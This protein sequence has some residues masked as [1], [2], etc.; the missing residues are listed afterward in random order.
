MVN[1]VEIKEVGPR[2]GAQFEG[3][4]DPLHWKTHE[5]V[6]LVYALARAGIKTI[7]VTS[8]VSPRAVPQMADAENVSSMLQLIPDVT[9]NAV[10]LD[11]RG[12]ARALAT[13]KYKITGRILLSASDA[14]AM[15]N[16]RRTLDQD[17]DEQRYLINEYHA[18]ATPVTEGVVMAAFGCNYEGAIS[19]QR[20]LERCRLLMDLARSAGDSLQD[21]CLAD[22]MGWADP[23]QIRRTVDTIWQRWPHLRL[24]LHLHDTRGMG[25]ANVYAGLLAGVQKYETAIGGLGGCPFSGVAAGN[26]PTEDV[27]FL[28]EKMGIKTGLHL[29]RLVACVKLAED[30]VGHKLPGRISHVLVPS[31][32]DFQA[33]KT[34]A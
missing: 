23:E 26:V 5:K 28:C 29:G 33:V 31:S 34:G 18:H 25:M 12:L 6:R 20:V 13:Q 30:M 9:F 7:E 17:L 10:Y 27:A 4:N 22:T 14:F 19:I 21:L 3:I 32:D 16:V 11:R 1:S 24:S 2:E 8:F 15:A